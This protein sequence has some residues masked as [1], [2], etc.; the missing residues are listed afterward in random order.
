MPN[1]FVDYSNATSLMN[2]IATKLR[3]LNGSYI[4]KGSVAFAYRPSP[5]TEAM[6]GWVYNITDDFTTDATFVDGAGKKCAAGT[7]IAVADLSTYDT[8]TPA[9]SENPVTEGWYELVGGRYVLSEDTTVDPEKTYYAKTVLVKWDILGEWADLDDLT[10]AI[11]AL[12]ASIAADFDASSAYNEGDIVMYQNSL[13]QFKAGGH[14]AGDPWNASEVDA[15]T[16]IDLI[17][18][19]EPASLTPAQVTTL[20][21]LLD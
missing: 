14:T 13:Y 1:N 17:D 4:F 6:N 3:A 5:I 15:V 7:N 18:D 12:S 19:A 20:I 21:G 2:A 11:A 9:G 8:V 10:N 16:I